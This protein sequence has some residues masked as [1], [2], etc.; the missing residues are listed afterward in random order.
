MKRF[1]LAVLVSLLA[2]HGAFAQGPR[3]DM[4][5]GWLSEAEEISLARE[6]TS[7]QGN[8]AAARSVIRNIAIDIFNAQPNLT[9]AD[10]YQLVV[11][12]ARG[13]PERLAAAE[14][15]NPEHDTELLRLKP[16]I[17]EATRAGRLAEAERHQV[18]FN[19]RF[20]H[21]L[22]ESRQRFEAQTLQ[23]A[24][25]WQSAGDLATAQA[26]WRAA[27]AHY[28]RAAQAAPESNPHRR[29]ELRVWQGDAL[30]EQGTRFETDALIEARLV[31]EQ[32]ALP[33]VPRVTDGQGW[34]MTQV[35]LGNVLQALGTRQDGQAG[36][37]NLAASRAA[38]ER[39]LE[40]TTRATDA[41]LWARTQNNLGIV[42]QVLGAR[43][44]GQAGLDTLAASRAAYERALEVQ[45]RAT[46]AQGWA[47]T[48]MNLGIVLRVL[49]ERQD[50]QAGLESLAAARAAF[51]RALEVTTRAA[52]AWLWPRTQNNLGN[53][54]FRLGERQGGQ[55][56]LESLEAARAAYARA[57]E[58]Q[59]RAT[60]AQG[61][62]VTQMNLGIVLQV[63]GARQGGQAGLDTLAASRAAY[64]RALE[65]RTRATD[66]QGWAQTQMNLGIVLRALGARQ[67]GQAGLE[68]LEASRAAYERALEVRT[69]A[70]DAQ[71]W[72]ETQVNL[73][74]LEE[75]IGD[76][77]GGRAAYARAAAH[78]RAALEVFRDGA[79]RRI[80]EANLA[81]A[82][83]KLAA[84][85]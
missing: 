47:V 83:R 25:N 44:G 18:A 37:E 68:S 3:V 61:W 80:A 36:L 53:V 78:A 65:V 35:K 70:T 38:Y 7:A 21:F 10:Y 60:D 54:L 23:Q 58:V 15:L 4:R 14:A 27:A 75:A 64:E 9:P 20:E 26:A 1:V 59:T 55:A 39:A 31:Y 48:Q 76:L 57:L 2:V 62:A 81:N 51:E 40:V 28:G 82:E 19:E 13:L 11:A 8:L 73:G 41:W 29:W 42:L 84:A 77:G 72:A 34:A 74:A 46:D 43:Q 63:L 67:G 6:F 32:A 22:S 71:G 50:G 69:R 49:G 79:H 56:G 24:A 17:I 85:R 16:L 12:G 66:A 45:T 5:P 33:L 52:D 30:Y